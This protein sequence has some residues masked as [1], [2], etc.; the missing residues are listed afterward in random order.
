[1][2]SLSAFWLITFPTSSRSFK[3]S[4]TDIELSLAVLAISISQ[5]SIFEEL[6][7]AIS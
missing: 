5:K 1:M 7:Q 3:S 4:S 6:E 2:A